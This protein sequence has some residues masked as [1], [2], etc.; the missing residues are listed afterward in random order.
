M[1]G[2]GT[3]FVALLALALPLTPAPVHQDGDN[4]IVRPA[5]PCSIF[6]FPSGRRVSAARYSPARYQSGG[7]PP[8]PQMAVGGGE[9]LLAIT[10]DR[11]GLVAALRPLRA[12]PPFTDLVIDA[13][14]GW[15]FAPATEVT[16]DPGRSGEPRRTPVA[17]TVLVAA[18]FRP[19]ALRGPTLGELPEDV[20]AA[21]P[22]TAFPLSTTMPP[23][24]P[25]A[26]SG[27]VVLL[28]AL[29]GADGAMADATIIRP[30]PP[31]DDAA[32]SALLRW[33]FRPARRA[34][35]PV[36]TFVYVLFGFRVPVVIGPP[37]GVIAPP[38]GDDG[39]AEPARL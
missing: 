4:R 26:R 7:L 25:T 22:E 14:R 2:S 8:L 15:R 3:L 9:V 18:V 24:P 32:R 10:V 12:T 38:A 28:E 1:R 31:F 5:F 30:A 6:H 16:G 27:G 19:P 33:T 23:Y 37:G 34:G 13:V 17:S 11:A 39:P 20:A 29:I 35:A 21:S 36:P